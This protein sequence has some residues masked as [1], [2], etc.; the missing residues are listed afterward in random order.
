MGTRD[1]VV[2]AADVGYGHVKF[3]DGIE[4]DGQAR[5]D[6]FPSQSP[7]SKDQSLAVGVMQRRDTF[8]VRIKNR[9]YE[10]GKGVALS[11]HGDHEHAILDK[12]FALSDG[13]MARL[14]GALNYM[15]PGLPDGL[16]DYLILG[17]PLNTYR[18]HRADVKSRYTG[19]FK[20]NTAGDEITIA[21]CE[22][23]PQP[24]GSYAAY[25]EISEHK[26]FPTA[27]VVDPGYNTVDWFVCQ[28]MTANEQLSSATLRGVSAVLKAIADSLIQ[29]LKLDAGVPEVVR[30]I[31]QTLMSGEPLTLYGEEI[32]LEKYLHAGDGVIEE[33]TQAVKNSI[34]SGVDIDVVVLSGGGAKLYAKAL[35]SKFPRHKIVTLNSPSFANVRGFQG[36]GE[37]LASSA[38][39]A[40]A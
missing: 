1:L 26:N 7:P 11:L 34:G 23:Y 15:A 14:F 9:T 40:M 32:E 21:N 27:L 25:L 28:G 37:L 8:A 3:T 31:D 2:R 29:D 30:K 22:V 6:S 13:Y 19:K 33:A 20:I 24:L 12:D 10:V 38:R 39:R 5:C 18:S 17:L 16:I 35:Q 36:L 4:S